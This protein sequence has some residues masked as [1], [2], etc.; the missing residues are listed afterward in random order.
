MIYTAIVKDGGLFIPNI[1]A[2]LAN[3]ALQ[4]Q[5]IQVKLTLVAS[6]N[7]HTMPNSM[8]QAVGLLQDVDG[9]TY[10]NTLRQTWD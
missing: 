8:T 7:N 2:D 3:Q 10:Q 1:S 4:A 5:S 6:A 9:V